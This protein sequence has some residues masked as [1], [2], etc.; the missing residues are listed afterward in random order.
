M[1]LSDLTALLPKP[2]RDRLE[3]LLRGGSRNLVLGGAALAAAVAIVGVLWSWSSSYAVLYAGL[4]SVEGGQAIADLQK[5]AI[6]Y[7]TEEGGRVILVPSDDLGRARLELAVRGVPKRNGDEWA[8]LD[9]ESLGVSPFVEQVHYNRAIES[10]L[11]HTIGQ[12]DGVVSATVRLALPKDTDFLGD[13]PKPSASVMLRLMPGV[14]LAATQ[15]DGIAG[16]VA[17]SVP[18]LSRDRVTI[19]D[20]TGKVLG[21]NDQHGLQAIPQQLGVTRD[22]ERGYERAIVDLLTPVLGNGNFRVSVDADIDFSRAKESSIHYGTSHIL[23]QDE[24]IHPPG[25]APEAPIGIPGALSNKPPPAP[26]VAPN[27]PETAVAAAPGAASPNAVAKPATTAK[28]AAPVPAPIPDT[29]RTTN[30]DLDHTVEY[31]EHPSWTLRA[32]DVAVLVNHPPGKPLP[33]AFAQSIR[34]LVTS[35]VGVGQDRHVAV[36]DLPF[37]SGAETFA[38]GAGAWWAQPWIAAVAQNAMLALGGLALLFGGLLPLLQRLD[39]SRLAAASAS[40]SAAPGVPAAVRPGVPPRL[41]AGT[42]YRPS[43]TNPD[44]ETVRNL[45]VSEPDRTAQ[46]IKEWIAR[47]RNRLKQAG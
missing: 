40:R 29:H 38:G 19:V 46:V 41:V 47:D 17:A 37:N 7:R 14:D 9:N 24:T 3:P 1:A 15:V 21:Q 45:V 32:L 28:P 42:A 43:L 13:E 10:T 25:S 20:Q 33:G 39:A 22:V 16:L 23:S 12:V 27:P 2:V 18:G 8:S 30:Y 4:S 36:V 26:V 5:L 35:A 11:S 34:T 31:L 44:P 6:P